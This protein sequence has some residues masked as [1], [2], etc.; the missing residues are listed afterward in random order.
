MYEV[1]RA[2]WGEDLVGHPDESA[3]FTT[4]VMMKDF[5]STPSAWTHPIDFASNFYTHYPKVLIGHWPPVFYVVEAAWFTVFGESIQAA[6]ALSL[7]FLA[8]LLIGVGAWVAADTNWILAIGAVA[9]LAMVPVVQ[10]CGAWVLADG[11]VAVLCLAAMFS[12]ARFIELGRRQDALCFSALAALAILTKGNAWVL[13]M[14]AFAAPALAGAWNLYRRPQFWLSLLMT[15]C[16]SAPFYLI[17]QKLQ[18]SYPLENLVMGAEV[19]VLWGRS[20]LLLGIMSAVPP[21]FWGLMLLGA[22]GAWRVQR[23]GRWAVCVTFCLST[24][25]FLVVSGLSFEDRVLLPMLALAVPLAV[26]GLVLLFRSPLWVSAVA[27]IPICILVSQ[28]SGNKFTPHLRN[29]YRDVD[30]ALPPSPSGVA[31]LVA[32]DAIGE[33]ALLVDH[34]SRDPLR[35]DFVIRGTKLLS[36][37]NANGQGYREIYSDDAAL[38]ADLRRVPVRYVAIDGWSRRLGTLRLQRVAQAN[39]TLIYTR[40]IGGR[41]TLVY[42]DPAALG[43][44]VERLRF[45]LGP[46]HGNRVME[47]KP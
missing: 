9:S 27:L 47:Y 18:S 11:L 4:G 22:A 12:W 8:L 17:A 35:K 25:I 5:L 7:A 30:A 28:S 1:E 24:V 36:Q 40:D 38:L 31:V 29:G 45:T 20:K 44:R 41:P 19:S 13:L 14:A 32:S 6:R 33:G 43:R 26:G 42:E 37:Q 23:R 16:L 2:V 15:T 34:L 3:H 10:V 46:W 39:F 21:L